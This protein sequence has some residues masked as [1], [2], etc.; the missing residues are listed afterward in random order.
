MQIHKMCYIQLL[1]T[2]I[3]R[4][5]ILTKSSRVHNGR[6]GIGGL[7]LWHRVGSNL[8]HSEKQIYVHIG[9][10]S[11]DISKGGSPIAR[12]FGTTR[13][14]RYGKFALWENFLSTVY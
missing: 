3:A 13:N 5:Y 12:I 7:P 2:A 11:R 4:L 8:Q 10:K 6:I 9:D 14:P 1:D